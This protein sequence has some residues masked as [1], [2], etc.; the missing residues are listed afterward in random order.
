[1]I[2]A[3]DRRAVHV[4]CY[5]NW[6]RGD[7]VTD[8]LRASADAWRDVHALDDAALARQVREDRIDVLVDLQGL[9]SGARAAILTHRGAPVQVSYLGYPGPSG[10]AAMATVLSFVGR[11]SLS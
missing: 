5:Y 1:M 10:L 9:T 3:H 2:E 6:H 8:R 4:T 7:E 11:K